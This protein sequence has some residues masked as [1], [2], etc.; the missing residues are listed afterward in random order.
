MRKYGGIYCK[1]ACSNINTSFC[2]LVSLYLI[3][4][5]WFE[6]AVKKSDEHLF[7]IIF[8]PYLLY[9]H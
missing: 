1:L 8:L 5:N 9:I 4:E 6:K 7:E 2:E 3:F